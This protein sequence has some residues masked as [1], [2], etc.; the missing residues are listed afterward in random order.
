LDVT[1]YCIG[2]RYSH[3][4]KA[5]GLGNKFNS[6]ADR[7]LFLGVEEVYVND[8][9]D[10]LDALKVLITGRRIEIEAMIQN[11]DIGFVR[12]GPPAEVKLETFNF[13]R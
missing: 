13:T 2:E 9:W 11:K 3:L 12:P 5:A 10:L 6:W 4:P 8:R 1:Q 7:K